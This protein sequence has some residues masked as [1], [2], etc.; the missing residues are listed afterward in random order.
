M[1]ANMRSALARGLKEVMA[2]KP[3]GHTLSIAAGGPSLADTIGEIEGHIAAMNGSLKFLLERGIVP[4]FC[5]VLDSSPHMA[6]IVVADPRVRYLVASNCDP[7]LFDKLLEAG[8]RVWLWHPTP[9]S[10]GTEDGAR[11][12]KAAHPDNW[13][14]IAG[15][16]TMG[17]RWVNLG[18][19]LGYR[20]FHLHG[21]DS[22]FRGTETHAYGDRRSTRE[23]VE[24]SSIEIAGHKTSLNFLQQVEDFAAMLERFSA[25]DIEPVSV[26]VHGSGLLQTC[27]TRWL[28][29]L[30]V[31]PQEAFRRVLE[32]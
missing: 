20:D 17:L 27:W 28:S 24:S 25:E 12:V 2:C 26:A 32:C 8:C 16:S 5:G 31:R 13:L 3:H 14:M 11:V 1:V 30:S 23:W 29:D 22:S 10:I 4:E 15:G 6:D 19:V 9:Y 18:Y 21:L 7:A